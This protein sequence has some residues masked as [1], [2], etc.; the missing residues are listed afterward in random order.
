MDLCAHFRQFHSSEFGQFSNDTVILF[1]GDNGCFLVL[2]DNRLNL[3]I[4]K[5]DGDRVMTSLRNN[6]VRVAL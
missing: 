4:Q 5:I 3:R 6:N 2:R 1:N